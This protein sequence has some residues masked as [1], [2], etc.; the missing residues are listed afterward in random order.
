M[1]AKQRPWS[2]HTLVSNNGGVLAASKWLRGQQ[3]SSTDKQ[4]NS[5]FLAVDGNYNDASWRPFSRTISHPLRKA[6][7][8]CALSMPK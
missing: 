6:N 3:R 5:E 7:D 1:K 4:Y 8:Y 2:T